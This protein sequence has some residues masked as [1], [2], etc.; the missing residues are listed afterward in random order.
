MEMT[1]KST[2]LDRIFPILCIQDGVIISKRGELTIGW[3]VSL[4]TIWSM[5]EER[6]DDMLEALCSAVRML[7]PK[8][9]VHR[10]DIYTKEQYHAKKGSGILG[11]AYERH[12]DSREH[13]IHRQ[14]LYLTLAGNEAISRQISDASI[15]GISIPNAKEMGNNLANLASK[16]AEFES[17]LTSRGCFGLERLSEEQMTT[18]MDAHLR[19]H[20]K[21]SIYSDLEISGSKVKSAN[22]S[23]W[24][25]SISKSSILP[26]SISPSKRSELVS[27]TSSGLHSCTA[28]AIGPLLGCEHMVNTYIFTINQQEN[29]REMDARKRRMTSMQKNSENKIGAEELSEFMDLSHKESMV[30]VKAHTNILVWGEDSQEQELRGKVSSAL[31]GMNIICVQDTYSTPVLW[32]SAFPGAAG[33]I[34]T[35]NL[36]TR[37]LKSFL[38]LGI[39]ETF[40]K[41]MPAGTLKMCDRIRHIPLQIDIQ[42]EAYKAGLI[43]NYNAFVL[44]GSGT[45]KSFFTNYFVRSCYD[46]GQTVF[47]IDVGDS[48]QGL[49]SVINEESKGID[50]IYH[51]WDRNSPITFDAFIGINDW[52]DSTGR[53]QQENDGLNFLLSFLQTLW[54]PNGG[55]N[56]DSGN[57]LKQ[58]IRD[59]CFARKDVQQRPIFDDLRAFIVTEIAPQIHSAEGYKCG[60]VL[61]TT[62]R[63]DIDGLVLSM[64]DYSTGGPFGF[65]LNDR[66]P[67]DLF[68]SRFTV[69][70]VDK[71]SGINDSRFYSLCILCIMN[72]FNAKMRNTPGMKVM[73]IEEAWKAIANET[74]S[75]Y[76]AGLWKTARKFQTSAVVV[77]QQVSDIMS[78]QVVRDTILQNSSVRILLDQSN[79]RNSFSQLQEL[80][81]LTD[82]QKDVILSMNR[83]KKKGAQYR[84]VFIALGDKKYGVYATEVSPEEAIAYES[85]KEKKRPFLELSAVIG[86]AAAIRQLVGEE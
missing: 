61:V 67:R 9:I 53:L 26:T 44:G 54:G 66:N 36:M 33:E 81:G 1:I 70:E 13:L 42:A 19:L 18:L 74:M 72:S 86:P 48:Y 28:A 32:A 84:E 12:F 68:S 63:F 47:I 52:I 22:C 16:A 30:C 21:D 57:I 39:N 25:Y 7:G 79:N 71:L 37:E 75:G 49:C 3:E 59:F 77:T 85:N 41:E 17:L 14:Y 83:G 43:D 2:P 5:T 51:T 62:K 20:Q 24:G 31:A 34:S 11:N 55:W 78:S 60:D 65:L 35:D 4:P 27:G 64:G 50:G 8:M 56:A 23:L 82:H 29:T 58:I 46:A 40:D 15:F 38:C 10:Q 45:G 73:V 6:H 80:L 76:L 69:F